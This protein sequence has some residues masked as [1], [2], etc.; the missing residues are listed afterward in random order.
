MVKPQ[1]FKPPSTLTKTRWQKKFLL[2]SEQPK[3]GSWLFFKE[4]GVGCK[5]C[6][7]RDSQDEFGKA[8]A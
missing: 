8:V 6:H 7:L 3:L 5:A 4:G 2:C 1:R